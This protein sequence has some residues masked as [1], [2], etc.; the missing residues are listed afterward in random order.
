MLSEIMLIA[1]VIV[2]APKPPGSKTLISR[3]A[4]VD[5]IAAA[6]VWTLKV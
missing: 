2:T 5:N 3:P 6:K 1:L 4:A